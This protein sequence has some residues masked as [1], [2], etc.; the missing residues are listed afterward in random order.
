[1]LP[2]ILKLLETGQEPRSQRIDRP[3]HL[4]QCSWLYSPGA[5]CPGRWRWRSALLLGLVYIHIV[6]ED[7]HLSSTTSKIAVSL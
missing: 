2:I 3:S 4:S 5:K 6:V 1:M 7:G